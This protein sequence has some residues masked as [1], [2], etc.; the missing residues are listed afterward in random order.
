[1][2]EKAKAL[3]DSPPRPGLAPVFPHPAFLDPMCHK[4]FQK[5]VSITILSTSLCHF[6][7]RSWY[8]GANQCQQLSLEIGVFSGREVPGTWLVG[9]EPQ[10]KGEVALTNKDSEKQSCT[11]WILETDHGKLHYSGFSRGI[12][13]M[14]GIYRAQESSS[15]SSVHKAGCLNWPSVHTRILK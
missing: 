9:K 4:V 1:M 12:G 5:P 7:P 14:E 2:A 11:R 15:S 6:C 13:L 3:R 10:S 8:H